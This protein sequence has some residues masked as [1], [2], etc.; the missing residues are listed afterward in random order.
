M[1]LL[2]SESLPRASVSAKGMPPASDECNGGNAS[3]NYCHRRVADRGSRLDD[4]ALVVDDFRLDAECR[5]GRHDPVVGVHLDSR[6]EFDADYSDI[7]TRAE[8]R[9]GPPYDRK[10]VRDGSGPQRVA[11]DRRAGQ[12]IAGRDIPAVAARA[13]AGSLHR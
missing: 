2:G 11:C 6:R 5:S 7:A 4:S 9:H 10:R 13:G 3:V 8:A 12:V 1:L